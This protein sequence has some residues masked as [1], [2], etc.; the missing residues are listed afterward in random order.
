MA[1]SGGEH[2]GIR[3]ARH[4]F[5]GRHFVGL[6]DL[7]RV[8]EPLDQLDEVVREAVVVIDDEDHRLGP[9]MAV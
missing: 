4:E 3:F 5:L 1:R 2:N 9:M 8:S 6:H 7:R